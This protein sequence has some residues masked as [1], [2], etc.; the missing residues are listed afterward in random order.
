M[1]RFFPAQRVLKPAPSAT[2]P[3]ISRRPRRGVFRSDLLSESA[4]ELV[5]LNTPHIIPPYRSP[6]R[7]ISRLAKVSRRQRYVV[8][9]EVYEHDAGRRSCQRAPLGIA[10]AGGLPFLVGK[11]FRAGWKVVFACVFKRRNAPTAGT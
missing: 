8:S 4:R 7:R 3:A 9:D 5:I 1:R 10:E 6:R 2:P 11:T